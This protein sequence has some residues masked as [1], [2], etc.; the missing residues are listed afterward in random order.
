[1]QIDVNSLPTNP[2][3]LQ[4]M[5]VN[6]LT[7]NAQQKQELDKLKFQI[8]KI[9]RSQYGSKSE[10]IQPGQQV[11]EGFVEVI[12]DAKTEA[13][14]CQV[15]KQRTPSEKRGGHG[16]KI[17]P[18]GLPRK[19]IF[20][21]IQQDEKNCAECGQEL[22]QIGEDVSEKV[23]YAPPRYIVLKYHRKKLACK[24]CQEN[25]VTAKMPPSPIDKGLAA[26]GLL[27]H[28]ILCKYGDHLPLY[29]QGQIFARNGI[30]FSM[31]TMCDWIRQCADVLEPIWDCIKKDVLASYVV[32][33]DDTPVPVLDDTLTHARKGRIWIYVG[34]MGHR[35]IIYDYSP[36]REKKYPEKFFGVGTPNQYRGR[37]QADAFTGYNAMFDLDGIIEVACWAH[38]RRYFFDAQE[39]NMEQAMT[40]LTMIG[41]LYKVESEMKEASEQR[42]AVGG[43]PLTP[44]EI[45]ERRQK[46]S[47]P[48]MKQIK[49]W[50]D[51]Q[52]KTALP[53]SPVGEAINYTLSQWIALTRYLEDGRLDIDNN[54]AERGLRMVAVGRKNYLFF[55]GDTG[56]RWAAIHYTLI[57]SCKEN[58]VEPFAYLRDVLVRILTHPPEKIRELM[59]ANWKKLF[60][61]SNANSPSYCNELDSS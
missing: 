34:D 55:G 56:G 2:K 58:G 7:E 41:M 50:L 60:G 21:D 44:D 40:M 54:R 45:R 6:L 19:D 10:R 17:I 5:V 22:K 48:I 4:E 35:N 51:A 16:R 14:I 1:M 20:I 29:R 39:S 25:V 47:V 59:P 28:V 26:P 23:E 18:P 38:A 42:V 31:S 24:N 27:A 61:K 15:P 57:A 3:I 9:Q 53:K 37:I 33:T 46:H 43:I 8:H 49:E 11:F 36:T 12:E 13:S 32:N 52:V 30:H